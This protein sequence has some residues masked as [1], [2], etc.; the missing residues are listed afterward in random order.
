MQVIQIASLAVPLKWLLLG[1]SIIFGLFFIRMWLHQTQAKAV[2]KRVFDVLGNSVFLCF[3]LWKVSLVLTDPAL[4]LKSPMSLL[5][6]T[7]GTAGLILAVFGSLGYFYW[8]SI[9]LKV[10]PLL[11]LQSL[12]FY[13]LAIL[14]GYRIL[15]YALVNA[16]R[17]SD[18]ILGIL[19]FIVL[20]LALFK[21]NMLSKKVIISLS[22][23][24]GGMALLDYASV[25]AGG[26]K[27][28]SNQEAV[29]T[30]AKMGIEEG[31][32][33]ADFELET[34]AGEAISLSKM[35]GKKVI[36]NFW[37]T[38]CPPCKAEMPHM[39][40]FYEKQNG[41]NIEIL[42]VNLTTAEK[43]P[44][45]ISRFADDYELTFPILLDHTGEIG[46]LYRARTIP[47]SYIIDS[48]GIIRNKIVGPMDK[49][50]MTEL[51]NSI[52]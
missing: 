23:A 35:K 38:W 10:P 29:Q 26:E 14:G 3:I 22:M 15:A 49:K 41:D 21:R 34:L 47:T 6:F 44:E 42:A 11:M 1:I 19:A 40:E 39:Q 2:A 50:M 17:I 18:L 27:A 5:Y 36:L 4:V 28:G 48:N 12:F 31:N 25:L 45:H 24:V 30:S 16:P 43:N 7:G 46:N 37:A 52:E 32:L 20:I 33:A 9:K 13:S 51:I 8:K